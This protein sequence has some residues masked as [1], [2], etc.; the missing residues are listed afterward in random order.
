MCDRGCLRAAL[1]HRAGELD[2]TPVVL[3]VG[4]ELVACEEPLGAVARAGC[5]DVSALLARLPA[6]GDD[7]RALD[8]SSLLAV[9]VLGI[10]EA[11][12][13]EVG[14]GELDAAV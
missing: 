4:A 2:D 3:A 11:Y 13:V 10:C 12:R 6:A 8:G 9:D 14:Q 1:A 5:L 7:H